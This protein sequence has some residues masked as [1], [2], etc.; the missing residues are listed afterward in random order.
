MAEKMKQQ[1][2]EKPVA[3]TF[4][5]WQGLKKRKGD[6]ADLRRA[7]T[8]NEVFFVPAYHR[9]YNKLNPTGWRSK[10]N[11]ALMAGILARID[12]HKGVT[13]FAAQMAS[14]GK[15]GKGAQVKGMRFRRLLQN[16]DSEDVYGP[17]IRI[18]NLMDKQANV[19]DLARCLY[20]WN[21][22]TRREWAF[23]Y[24]EKAPDEN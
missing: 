12:K 22:G 6:R 10:K 1:K 7:K 17:M 4:E 16:K 23:E 19:M 11:I 14:A 9:L 20:W 8:M 21:E 24:Y 2:N 15:S 18:I 13:R 3:L 5:W